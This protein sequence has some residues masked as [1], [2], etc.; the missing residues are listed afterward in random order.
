MG[1]NR[2]DLR[3][4]DGGTDF[5]DN[6][7]VGVMGLVTFWESRRETSELTEVCSLVV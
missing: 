7:G 5:R 4:G 6:L 2:T 3:A 1:D